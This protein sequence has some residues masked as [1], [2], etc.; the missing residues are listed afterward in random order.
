MISEPKKLIRTLREGPWE[1]T[2]GEV[3]GGGLRRALEEDGE[4][5]A[6]EG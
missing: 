5:E 2:W 6:A 1:W 4:Q 3:A